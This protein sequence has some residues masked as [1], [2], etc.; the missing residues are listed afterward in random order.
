MPA[1]RGCSAHLE[2]DLPVLAKKHQKC[3]ATLRTILIANLAFTTMSAI[4]SSAVQMEQTVLRI[5]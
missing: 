4:E 3:V 1:G 2:K 5:L